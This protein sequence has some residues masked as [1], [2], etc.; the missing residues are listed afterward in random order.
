MATALNRA[1]ADA[2]AFRAEKL[3]ELE[4]RSQDIKHE[5]S[6]LLKDRS[7]LFEQEYRRRSET[8]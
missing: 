6:Q 8:S 1:L 7:Q 3:R 5:T 2:E 4:Q